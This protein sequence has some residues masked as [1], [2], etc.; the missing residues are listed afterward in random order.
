MKVRVINTKTKR[1]VPSF[2]LHLYYDQRGNRG[3]GVIVDI[4]VESMRKYLQTYNGLGRLIMHCIYPSENN[5]GTM[6]IY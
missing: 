1:E 6:W 5:F 2:M 3:I 4:S